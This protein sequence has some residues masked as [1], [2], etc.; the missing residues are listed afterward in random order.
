MNSKRLALLLSC[1]ILYCTCVFA[2]RQNET[3]LRGTVI[4]T[5]GE[6]AGFATAYLTNAEGAI[7]CGGTADGDGRFELRAAYGEY[8][9]TVSLVGYKDASQQVRLSAAQMELMPIRLEEDSEL[10]GE[11]IVQAVMPKTRITGEGL[12]TSVHGSVLENAGTARDVLGKVPGLI[13]GRDGIEVIGKGSPVIYVNGHKVTDSGELDRLLSHEIQSVEVISNPGA[14]YDATVRAVVRIRTVKRQGEGFGF[15]VNLSDS[16]SLRRKENNDPAAS[17]NANYRNGGLDFFGGVNVARES[18]I[19]LSDI[20]QETQ[21]EALFKQ[22]GIIDA[23]FTGKAAGLNGGFNWQI[24]D[25]HFAGFKAD[26]NRP[27]HYDEN[28][29]IDG[30]IYLDGVHYDHLN[31]LSEG[32]LGSRTPGSLSANAYYNGTAGKLGIDLNLDYFGMSDNKLSR[33]VEKSVIEDATVTTESLSDNRL[34]AGKLVFSYPV[35]KGALQFGTEETFSRRSDDYSLKGAAVP[36]SSTRVREDNYAGFVNY[37]F[38]LGNIG[39]VGAGLRYEH[40][41]YFYDDLLGNDSFS[42]R[43]DNFFPSLSFAGAIG[44]VQ[45]MLSYSERTARPSFSMLSS[46]IRYNNRYTLQGGN[47]KLQP[48]ILHDFSLTSLWKFF[49]F[50]MNYNRIDN[51][52]ITWAV[53][54]NSEGVIM[55]QPFNLGV[56]VRG[57]SA[58][59]NATPTVGVWTMGYTVGVQQ[60]WLNVDVADLGASY[61]KVVSFNDKP[62]WIAQLLNTF[63]LKKGWQLEFGGEYHSPGYAQNVM[64]T[65]HFLDLS[66]AVQK[67]LLRD[68]SL[69]LRLEGRDLAGLGYNNVFTELG[70]Y[71]ITQSVITDTQRV[72]FSV[73]YRFNSADSKYKGTGAGKDARSRMD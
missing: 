36:A 19:Q 11:A 51:P 43:Y 60:S 44:P 32:S 27:Y 34:Y 54:Y 4:D 22:E 17:F 48:Q 71:R 41:D 42:K 1:A 26:W 31:T 72:V 47:A 63:S 46:A 49:T 20:I 59:L 62:I 66:A 39:Q 37:G 6:P 40:V 73:R 68:G 18:E 57:L 25:N 12:A 53:P 50:V 16:Q 23:D 61:S 65:N 15:N 45:T 52:I 7:V 14:Q 8:T 5:A 2:A 58:F 21:G 10:L 38:M 67:T 33:S 55:L 30:D 9:L 3:T 13:K 69:V 29:L 24:S 35:W 70:S 56:P 28:V 64:I